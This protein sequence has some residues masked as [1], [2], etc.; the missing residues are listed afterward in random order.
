MSDRG[1]RPPETGLASMRIGVEFG[2][3]TDFAGMLRLVNDRRLEPVIDSVLPLDEG[4]LAL[5]R[6]SQGKQFGKIVLAVD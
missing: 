3:P 5:Q 1:T 4:C 2:S 6:L